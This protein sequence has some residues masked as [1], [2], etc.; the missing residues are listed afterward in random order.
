MQFFFYD[1][2]DTTESWVNYDNQT[3]DVD[4]RPAMQRQFHKRTK[5]VQFWMKHLKKVHE[6]ISTSYIIT[7]L[8][9]E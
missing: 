2:P 4:A 9:T 7:V 8:T 5:S 3:N 1:Q 6:N